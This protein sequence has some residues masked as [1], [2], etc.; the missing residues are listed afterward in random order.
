M[1]Y[2][3]NIF[4]INNHLLTFNNS[5]SSVMPL[6]VMMSRDST[7]S[8]TNQYL[9][10][11]KLKIVQ[12][13]QKKNIREIIHFIKLLLVGINRIDR[14]YNIDCIYNIFFIYYN[15]LLW[16]CVLCTKYCFLWHFMWSLF[17]YQNWIRKLPLSHIPVPMYSSIL[18][19]TLLVILS[20]KYSCSPTVLFNQSSQL[21]YYIVQIS[22]EFDR[23]EVKVVS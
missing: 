16:S 22:R 11:A 4:F 13:K 7:S 9:K 14:W 23:N 18:S 1:L 3:N 6:C 17:I 20:I 10:Q 21:D 15:F 19:I 12:L 5:P 8:T 2:F